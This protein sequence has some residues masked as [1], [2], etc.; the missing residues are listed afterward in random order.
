MWIRNKCLMWCK[1]L[2]K[3]GWFHDLNHDSTK[4]QMSVTKKIVSENKKHNY[5]RIS[6]LV[7]FLINYSERLTS[8]SRKSSLKEIP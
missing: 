1:S 8:P 3:T 7:S 4:L 6:T 2:G 5:Y